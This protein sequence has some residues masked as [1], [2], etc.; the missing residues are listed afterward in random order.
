[1]ALKENVPC[2]YRDTFGNLVFSGSAIGLPFEKRVSDLCEALTASES[3]KWKWMLEKLQTLCCLNY[4][5]DRCR[6]VMY[7][8]KHNRISVEFPIANR[9]LAFDLCNDFNIFTLCSSPDTLYGTH[10]GKELDFTFTYGRAMLCLDVLNTLPTLE[11]TEM[12]D[13]EWKLFYVRTMTEIQ[14]GLG[15]LN[16]NLTTK[17][18]LISTIKEVNEMYV[19][20]IEARN[21]FN[22]ELLK[23]HSELE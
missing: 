20:G 22:R 1:M 19:R 7:E 9:F 5:P 8:S 17:D 11:G 4:F 3:E 15:D 23:L 16:P 18:I 21:K 13:E 12:N 6:L 2:V 10:N 14:R